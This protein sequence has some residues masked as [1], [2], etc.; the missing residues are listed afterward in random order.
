[1]KVTELEL[2]DI[3]TT[4]D[5]EDLVF[6]NIDEEPFRVYGI[7][8]EGD[9]YR[10]IPESVANKCNDFLKSYQETA[11]GGRV[12][13]ITTSEYIS[14]RV[15]LTGAV[16]KDNMTDALASGG[17][18]YVGTRY[19]A[20]VKNNGIFN[21][22]TG[23]KLPGVLESAEGGVKE[24]P[25][26]V[27][28]A[29]EAVVGLGDTKGE[30]VTLNLPVFN[31]VKNVYIGLQKDTEISHA[32]DYELE[33]PI[34]FYGSSITHGASASRPGNI[35]EN[36]LSRELGFNYINLGFAGG[37]QGEEAVSE[38]IAG[39]D[40]SAFVF[41]YDHN[42]P[43]VEH[44]QDTHER[45]FLKFREK[46]PETP[47]LMLS[48][49]YGKMSA[50]VKARQDVV[51][52]TYENAKARGDENVW[53]VLGSEYFPEGLASDFS[54]DG[55]H[56]NDLGFKLMADAMKPALT[57]MIERVRSREIE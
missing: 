32:P 56:P 24:P 35:Y 1:M 47:V 51:R 43:T 11:A 57:E 25:E 10:R 4:T 53:L 38:Y 5:K 13:F 44:L 42:A 55:T 39:L 48:R 33:K 31:G 52:A 21:E 37:A 29:Y 7:Y 46:H 40:M 30:T 8:R 14:V 20:T 22:K 16:R 26:G 23:E 12:R 54:V 50:D 17:D 27:D 2:S 45:M 19:Y 49:P 41:D 18:V 28:I 6:V 9:R 3:K 15:T 36:Q 34:V